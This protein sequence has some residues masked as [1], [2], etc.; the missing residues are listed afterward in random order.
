MRD[1]GRERGGEREGERVR[2][3]PCADA[4]GADLATRWVEADADAGV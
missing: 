2:R 4:G 1:K 3:W